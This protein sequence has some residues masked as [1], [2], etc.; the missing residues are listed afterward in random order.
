MIK[1]CV[2]I[3]EKNVTFHNGD[4]LTAKDVAWCLCQLLHLPL[5][6]PIQEITI[7]DTWT[8]DIILS[9]SCTYVLDLLTDIQSSIYK[10]E[11]NVVYGTG[12]FAISTYTDDQIILKAYDNYFGM[13]ALLQ[14]VELN[15]LPKT[16]NSF[17]SNK[18]LY[19]YSS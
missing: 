8:I 18:F 19:F 11:D 1:N 5:W 3:C 17:F 7:V 6:R 4:L 10:I 12:S 9:E 16:L 2:F 14:T 15:L 13:K